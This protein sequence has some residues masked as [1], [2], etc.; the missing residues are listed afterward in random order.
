MDGVDG[1]VDD[2]VLVLGA[3]N[4]PGLLDAA[5][6]RP[7]RFDRVIY[8]P[9]PDELARRAIISMECTKWYNAISAYAASSRDPSESKSDS[10]TVTS[11]IRT[12]VT[13][14]ADIEKYFNVDILASEAVS[15]LMTGAEIIG[16]C[17]ETA[18]EMMRNLMGHQ[19][20]IGKRPASEMVESYMQSL[21]KTLETILTRTQPLLSKEHVLEE[22]TR[23]ESERR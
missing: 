12:T 4:R 14:A 22:Y 11:N 20:V 1:S 10:T 3:T 21:S 7:G 16:A 19:S 8:V 23:F 17:R 13:S 18:V 2:G 9:P 5:L 15:G 6:L